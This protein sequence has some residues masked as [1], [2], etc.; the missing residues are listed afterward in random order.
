MFTKMQDGTKEDWMVIGAA[1]M[2]EFKNNF[3]ALV[4]RFKVLR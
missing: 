2:E 3:K 1:H 4:L